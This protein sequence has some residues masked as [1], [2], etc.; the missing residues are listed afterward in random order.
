MKFN[1]ILKSLKY[2]QKKQ[3]RDLKKKVTISLHKG[4][5]LSSFSGFWTSAGKYR[6][7]FYNLDTCWIA[8]IMVLQLVPQKGVCARNYFSANDK[9]TDDSNDVN[10]ILLYCVSCSVRGRPKNESVSCFGWLP[11]INN[12]SFWLNP[13][14]SPEHSFSPNSQQQLAKGPLTLLILYQSH[15]PIRSYQEF[16]LPTLR[17]C[18]WQKSTPDLQW[19]WHIRLA[20]VPL[21]SG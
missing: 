1:P 10:E 11:T 8:R 3:E 7:N 6:D 16:L 18:F 12:S 20:L 5:F 4:P 17:S 9:E 2:H 19:Y 21:L 14:G 13:R 15:L